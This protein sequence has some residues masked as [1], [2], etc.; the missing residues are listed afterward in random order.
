VASKTIIYEQPLNELIRACLRLEHLFQQLK[1]YLQDE[2]PTGSRISLATLLDIVNVTD[3]PDLRNKLSR[4]LTHYAN[5]LAPFEQA[6]KVDSQRLREVLIKIDRFVDA[7]HLDHGRFAQNLRENEFL[8]SV[9]MHLA[10]PGG[11]CDFNFP[12]YHLWLQQPA[13]YRKQAITTWFKEFEQ[14][15]VIIS[16]ILQLT[17]DSSEF[18]PKIA[19]QGFYQESLT[20]TTASYHMIRVSLPT[21]LNFYPEISVGRHRLSI[22]FFSPN[23]ESSRTIQINQDV[24]F[25]LSCCV[26]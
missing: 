12:A 25:L 4:V 21:N 18:L 14:L 6:S 8:N 23:F 17:R 5:V 13:E 26:A 16:L 15:R 1:Y 2:S 11:I 20:P 19:Q 9:R 7:L 3:R 22:H 24:E 10:K